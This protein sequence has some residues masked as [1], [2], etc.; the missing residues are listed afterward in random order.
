MIESGS[1]YAYVGGIAGFTKAATNCTNTADITV[2]TNGSYVGGIAGKIEPNHRATTTI[3]NNKNQGNI[4]GADC[5]GGIFGY[6]YIDWS[7][8]RSYIT[9]FIVTECENSGNIRATK[10]CAGGIIGSQTNYYQNEL[11]Y[12]TISNCTNSGNTSAVKYAGGIIAYGECTKKD[13]NIWET[14]TST[15]SASGTNSGVKYGY[16]K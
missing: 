8:I 2:S 5:V 4:T 7:E 6:A 12:C 16:L 10:N 9:G 14:N 15:G 13:S 1:S 3:K 11:S